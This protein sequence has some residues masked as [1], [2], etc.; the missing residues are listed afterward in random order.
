MIAGLWKLSAADCAKLNLKDEYA[1]HKAVYSLFPD[2]RSAE[3]KKKDISS[4]FQYADKGGGYNSRMILLLANREPV[5]PSCGE[6][7]LKPVTVDF[8]SADYYGFQVIMNP[9]KRDKKSA[10]AVP[11]KGRENLIK[12]FCGKAENSWG[13]IADEN[14]LDVSGMSAVIFSKNGSTDI[15]YNKAVFKGVLTVK[16]RKKFQESFTHGIGKARAF[17]FGL[18]ELVPLLKNN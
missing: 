11:V 17:G 16:D 3:D 7:D 5:A 4:G 9:V 18:L 6:L 10:K 2:N 15:T 8:L 13:F 12:W 14:K 1:V